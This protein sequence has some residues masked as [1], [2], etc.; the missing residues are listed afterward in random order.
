MSLQ[1]I[2]DNSG[3]TTAVII[4]IEEWNIMRGEYPGIET[5]ESELP[6]WQKDIIDK[7]LK[8]IADNPQCLR[9]IE[10]LFNELDSEVD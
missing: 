9:P 10:E 1:Y 8:E 2:S 7:N 6:Q 3:H 5:I 4:P